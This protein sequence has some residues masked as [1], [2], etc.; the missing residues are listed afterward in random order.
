VLDCNA[1]IPRDVVILMNLI[2]TAAGRGERF[3]SQGIHRP[4]PL[5]RVHGKE[6]LLWALESFPVGIFDRWLIV[7]QRADAVRLSL[8]EPLIENFPGQNIGWLELDSILNGQLQTSYFA[9]R[10][11]AL[12]GPLFIHNCDTGFRW[13]ETLISK[14]AYGT[15]PVFRA[16]GESWSFVAVDPSSPSNALEVREKKRISDL[17]SIGLYG[18]SSAEEFLHDAEAAIKSRK[19]MVNGEHF[20]APIYNQAIQRGAA[21]HVPVVDGI[22]LFGTP[23]QACQTFGIRMEDLI[24]ENKV[25]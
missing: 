15:I 19:L 2:I 3:R 5:I 9:V 22:K 16:E 10:H 23:Q 20:I 18:F 24:D 8:E 17:A 13:N 4:K 1:C 21:V 14:E 11:F 6:F 12:S 7:C 25:D